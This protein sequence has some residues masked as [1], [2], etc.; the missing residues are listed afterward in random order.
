MPHVVIY[1]KQVY[2]MGEYPT[3]TQFCLLI[4]HVR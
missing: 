1:S 2:P 3:E 4:G